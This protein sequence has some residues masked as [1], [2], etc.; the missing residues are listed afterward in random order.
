M[1]PLG[2]GSWEDLVSWPVREARPV[3]RKSSREE[4]ED[5]GRRLF[6]ASFAEKVRILWQTTLLD[7]SRDDRHVRVCLHLRDADDCSGWP[8]EWLYDSERRS[9]LSLSI[10]TPLVRY[11]ASLAAARPLRCHLPLRI[12]VVAASPPGVDR[13]DVQREWETLQTSLQNLVDRGDIQLDLLK[14]ATLPDLQRKLRQRFHILHF[15]GHGFYDRDQRE[16]GLLFEDGT[17]GSR[18]VTGRDLASL[19]SGRKTLSLIVLNACEGARTDAVAPFPGVAQ[20]LALTQVPAVVAMQFKISDPSAI[21]FAGHF[22]GALAEGDPVD[23][24]VAEARQAMFSSDWDGVEWGTPV[25]FLRSPDGRI[26][27]IVPEP[28]PCR[29]FR[30]LWQ[31]LKRTWVA[32]VLL[33]AGTV[34]LILGPCPSKSL[35]SSKPPNTEGCPRSKLLDLEFVRIEPGKFVMESKS[36]WL[37]K[38]RVYE[39][40]ITQPYC[41][42]TTEVTQEQWEKVMD[43]NPS[44]HKGDGRLPV[45]MVSYR[46]VNKFVENL[47]RLELGAGY[48]LSTEARWQYAA[49]AGTGHRYAF[50]DDEDELP[51]YGNCKGG[52]D[53]SDGTAPV[54]S[55]K[56]NRW[57]LHDMHGNVS[58]WVADWYAEYPWELRSDPEGPGT[59]TRRVR[60]GGSWNIIAKNCD[61]VTR[62]SAE[63]DYS[64]ND[65]GFRLVRKPLS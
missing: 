20:G 47:N 43:Y 25:L 7:A 6:N 51:T 49:Q 24:A 15:I 57:G 16:G 8:W 32:L 3:G 53:G 61:A 44:D 17:G 29:F 14:R 35:D 54:A 52:N 18:R 19:I 2:E 12:L 48:A 56:P 55:L 65:L 21:T 36:K 38:K 58:E 23:V 50:G 31:S 45:E 42:S 60:R 27:E 46:D 63:P 9:F 40:E 30:W 10:D 28:W 59:G 41:M 22:Y 5:I 11:P 4:V 26:F 39:V 1:S 13:I 34:G 33:V 64:S 37:G 62:N